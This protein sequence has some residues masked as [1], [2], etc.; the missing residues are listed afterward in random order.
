MKGFIFTSFFNLLLMCMCVCFSVCLY[1]WIL[2]LE[3]P[4]GGL[5]SPGSAITDVN[6]CMWVQGTELQ[7]SETVVCTLN[8]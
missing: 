1:T 4:E 7:S 3:E 5:R 2:E 8:H 6:H